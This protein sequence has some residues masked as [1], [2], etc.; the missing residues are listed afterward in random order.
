VITP[1]GEF[2]GINPPEAN[3]ELIA[4]FLAKYPSYKD[5]F[6]LSVKGGLQ[7]MAPDASEANLR[8]SVDNINA[9]LGGRTMDLFE[10]ARVDPKVPI[11]QTMET[12]EML[13]KEGK[14]GHIGLSEVSA[15]TLRRACKVAKVAA[16]EIEISPWS[17]EEE[18]VKGASF[19]PRQG[20][21][22][23]TDTGR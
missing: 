13:R 14:F 23:G 20:R 17:F 21:G 7:K 9:K 10:M 22:M 11:E 15:D 3:L 2:Y 12:L 6:F 16:V 4:R 5:K 1:A 18:T 8:R 19:P